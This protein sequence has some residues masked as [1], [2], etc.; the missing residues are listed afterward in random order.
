MYFHDLE[1]VEDH[2]NVNL[3]IAWRPRSFI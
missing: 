3:D 1:D 2:N